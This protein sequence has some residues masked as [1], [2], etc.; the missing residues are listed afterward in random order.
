MSERTEPWAPGLGYSIPWS[1]KLN[2]ASGPHALDGFL[3]L[4]LPEWSFEEG[5]P[6]ED[7]AIEAITESHGLMYVAETNWP[8]VFSEFARVLKPGG[9]I[10]ITEDAADDPASERFGGWHDAVTLTS[11]KFVGKYLRHVGLVVVRG[12][13]QDTTAFVDRSLIQRWHGDE[14]KVMHV[15]GRKPLG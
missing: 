1:S 11:R 12:I 13:D 2:L 14:P 10:R 7:E 15:E 4:D 3:N 5:L 9:I 8:Y 6:F